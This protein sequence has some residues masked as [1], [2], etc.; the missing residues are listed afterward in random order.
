MLLI[1]FNL[2]LSLNPD[3][4]YLHPH[5]TPQMGTITSNN[6]TAPSIRRNHPLETVLL[7]SSDDSDG[8]F[9]GILKE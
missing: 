2:G 3:S 8:N 6:K 1:L 7:P 5:A 4:S 9:S